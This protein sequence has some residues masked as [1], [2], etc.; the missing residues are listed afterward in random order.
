MKEALDRH[1][2][3]ELE[4]G[5][6]TL[7]ELQERTPK[8]TGETAASWFMR[9]PRNTPE[10]LEWVISPE[11]RETIVRFLEYGTQ[12][13]VIE[14]VRAKA[15]RFEIDGEV[16]F[17]KLV[18]HPGTR[19]LGFVRLLRDEVWQKVTELNFEFRKIMASLAGG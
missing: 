9:V 17:A 11:G 2:T 18:H 15:L 19:P 14:P 13:H 5:H 7:M 8:K 3:E 6:W 16:I 4:L 1:R 12:P 10:V